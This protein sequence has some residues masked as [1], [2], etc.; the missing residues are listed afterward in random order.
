MVVAPDGSLVSTYR[1]TN[2]FEMDVPW[3]QPGEE[4]LSELLLL[5]EADHDNRL[6]LRI[7]LRDT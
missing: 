6:Q 5:H 1:K 4:G 2:L 3:A 7:W